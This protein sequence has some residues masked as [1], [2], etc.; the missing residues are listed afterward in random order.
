MYRES[1]PCVMLGIRA[2]DVRKGRLIH[3]L[4]N[5]FTSKNILVVL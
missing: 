4:Y 2:M 1:A 3:V 5:G